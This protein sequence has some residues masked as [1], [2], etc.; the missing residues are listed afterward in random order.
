MNPESITRRRLIGPFQGT[1]IARRNHHS[2]GLWFRIAS[3]VVTPT[4][5]ASVHTPRTHTDNGP[6]SSSQSLPF[7]SF[8]KSESDVNDQFCC[9]C[10]PWCSARC[11][12]RDPFVISPRP[13]DRR[14]PAGD[15]RQA[16]PAL[17]R[18]MVPLGSPLTPR[19]GLDCSY[20]GELPATSSPCRC[21]CFV[22]WQRMAHRS[23]LQNDY[24]LRDVGRLPQGTVRAR[25]CGQWTSERNSTELR[26][27]LRPPQSLTPRPADKLAPDSP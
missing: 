8:A 1:T 7:V 14:A 21:G 23:T 25:L 26:F 15:L 27:R 22:P 6:D 11:R 12:A 3:M 13:A 2:P 24:L 17:D 19:T 20:P 4:P 10:F 16:Y 5:H 9:L 18:M